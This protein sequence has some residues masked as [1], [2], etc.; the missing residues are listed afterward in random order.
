MMLRGLVFVLLLFGA[1]HAAQGEDCGPEVL[2]RIVGQASKALTIMNKDKTASFQQRLREL[3]R[4]RGWTDQQ[5]LSLAAPIVENEAVAQ[6]DQRTKGIYA[7]ISSLGKADV[8][9]VDRDGRC[10]V[11]D[12]LDSLLTELVENNVQRWAMITDALEA[13][14]AK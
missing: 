13:E 1:V 14:L 2:K 8:G 9:K 4:K 12:K 10:V 5:M 6:Y 3:K 11:R 7:Q